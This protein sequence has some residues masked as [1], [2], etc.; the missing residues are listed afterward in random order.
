MTKT[1]SDIL[2]QEH[3]C[4]YCCA[5]SKFQNL[6]MGFDAFLAILIFIGVVLL[7]CFFYKRIRKRLNK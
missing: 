4:S 7:F 6:C 1:I 5:V 3:C 2:F